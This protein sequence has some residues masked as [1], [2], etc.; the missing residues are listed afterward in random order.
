M[1]GW[2]RPSKPPAVAGENYV[3]TAWWKCLNVFVIIIWVSCG[4]L[5]VNY[6]ERALWL[7]VRA[8]TLL[9]KWRISFWVQSTLRTPASTLKHLMRSRLFVALR[10]ITISNSNCLTSRISIHFIQFMK[11]FINWCPI[12]LNKIFFKYRSINSIL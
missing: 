12:C 10:S 9:P 5:K 6:S 2:A 3:S 4:I 7:L 11:Q 8:I 1:T